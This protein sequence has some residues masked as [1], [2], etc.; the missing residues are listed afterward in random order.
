MLF[1][2]GGRRSAGATHSPICRAPRARRGR[3]YEQPVEITLEEA[4]N[5]STRLLRREDGSTVEV[6]IPPGVT[7]GSR[8]RLSGEGGAAPAAR[9]ETSTW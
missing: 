7:T 3:D 2:G 4:F 5:G 1:G 9:P 8:V 6:K